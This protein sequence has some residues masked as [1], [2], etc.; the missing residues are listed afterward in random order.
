MD[1]GNILQAINGMNNG[2]NDQMADLNRRNENYKLIDQLNQEGVSL[3][4]LLTQINDLKKKVESLEKPAKEVDED[5]FAVMESAVKDD[6]AV[7]E[8][9]RRVS[10]EKNRVIAELCAKDPKFMA[11]RDE[12][13]R[14]INRIYVS[15]R[16]NGQTEQARREER[17]ET[18]CE[19]LCEDAPG[20]QD[21]Q[22]G[23]PQEP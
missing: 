15:R 9:K 1:Y 23:D 5:L 17:G 21:P 6:P 19:G 10:E 22:T 3:K 4:D 14:T 2:Q 11:A 7:I 18:S 20:G 12:Y 8:A 16:E 13:R